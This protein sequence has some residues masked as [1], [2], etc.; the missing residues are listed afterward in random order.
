MPDDSANSL[1][2]IAAILGAG[3]GG[4]GIVQIANVI[5]NRRKTQAEAIKIEA[6]AKKTETDA[7][8]RVEDFLTERM[9]TLI[10]AYETQ[11]SRQ[12]AECEQR[13]NDLKRIIESHAG[14]ISELNKQVYSQ[15]QEIIELRK[16]LDRQRSPTIFGT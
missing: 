11:A 10:S 16:A 1:G 14:T 3:I 9:K 12:A 5:A 6:D 7:L 13:C 8:M 4:G 2:Q 15:G